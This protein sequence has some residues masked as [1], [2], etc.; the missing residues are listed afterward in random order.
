MRI[1]NRL[2]ELG[3]VLPQPPRIPPGVVLPFGW[4]RICSTRAWISGHGPTDTDG[5]FA[6]PLGRVGAEVTPDEAYRAA[7]LTGLAILGSAAGARRS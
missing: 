7:R 2:Q 3:I 4:V 5:S 6:K 1:S